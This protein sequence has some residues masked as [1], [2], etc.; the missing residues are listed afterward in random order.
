LYPT[1]KFSSDARGLSREVDWEEV[2]KK[3]IMLEGFNESS[4]TSLAS[5]SCSRSWQGNLLLQGKGSK[6]IQVPGLL[7]N[8][9]ITPEVI[10]YQHSALLDPDLPA[11]ASSWAI[12]PLYPN[13]TRLCA[14]SGPRRS[15]PTSQSSC[16]R[17]RLTLPCRYFSYFGF[18]RQAMFIFLW[19]DGHFRQAEWS[20]T[21]NMH[22]L[23]PLHIL[24]GHVLFLRFC[25]QVT[26]GVSQHHDVHK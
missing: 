17:S 2:R 24:A 6:D 19:I 21:I 7:V 23:A 11:S 5:I 4:K 15:Q 8:S 10:R 9:S 16:P 26:R 18:Y 22:N 3:S 25:C 20:A 13:P 14:D 1:I 12:F